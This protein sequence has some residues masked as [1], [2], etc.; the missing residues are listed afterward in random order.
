MPFVLEERPSDS[1]FVEAIWRN[2]SERPESF[3]STAG[4]HWEMVWMRHKGQS[5]L[6][7][8]GPE[9]KATPADLPDEAEWLGIMFKLGS[10][11]PDFLP[12]GLLDRQDVNLPEG[13]GRTF[14][15]CGS[16]W[17]FP[18]YENVDTFVDR[19]VRAELLVRDS[20]VEDVLRDAP[21]DLSPRALQYRFQRATGLRRKAVQQIQRAWQATALLEQGY[22]ILETAYQL[23][24]FDQS[25]L[26]NSLR[27]YMGQTPAQI[28]QALQPEALRFFPRLHPFL[29]VS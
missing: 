26:T 28:S 11:M 16:T 12:G 2:Q 22:P 13:T 24:Y 19:L 5:T 8:R 9:T 23:G 15:L 21:L 4:I 1:S 14:W 29:V 6:T 3:I 7:V 25:H 10:F 17:E 18:T 27:R 20:L